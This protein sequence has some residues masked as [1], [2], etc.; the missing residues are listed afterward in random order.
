VKENEDMYVSL[1]SP[2][3]YRKIPVERFYNLKRYRSASFMS[4]GE[5]MSYLK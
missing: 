3:Q 4:T 1:N 5:F 2:S